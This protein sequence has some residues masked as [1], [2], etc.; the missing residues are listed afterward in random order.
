L[1]NA[2]IF[3]A[4]ASH[5]FEIY[6]QNFHE[7]LLIYYIN[8]NV[9]HGILKVFV[10]SIVV[11]HTYTVKFSFIHLSVPTRVGAVHAPPVPV[12]GA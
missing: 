9:V 12:G 11:T 5:Q 8:I 3:C 4:C 1:Q 2:V 10:P 6:S 7:N